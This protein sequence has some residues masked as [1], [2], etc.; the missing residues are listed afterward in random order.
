MKS[1]DK[2]HYKS[3]GITSIILTRLHREDNERTSQNPRGIIQG[4][5]SKPV[6]DIHACYRTIQ[7]NNCLYHK[8]LFIWYSQLNKT[9]TFMFVHNTGQH[10]LSQEYASLDCFKSI[11]GTW[12]PRTQ[13]SLYMKKKNSQHCNCDFYSKLQI[14]CSLPV[15]NNDTQGAKLTTQTTVN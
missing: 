11:I 1:A 2:L 8:S 5:N 7:F 13:I 4:L 10:G 9:L 12:I 3:T 6:R 14:V 15:Y